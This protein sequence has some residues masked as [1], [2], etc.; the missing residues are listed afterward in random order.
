ML[1][2]IREHQ[3]PAEELPATGRRHSTADSPTQQD[4]L[5]GSIPVDETRLETEARLLRLRLDLVLSNP[6]WKANC[7]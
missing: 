1:E 6:S 7:A 3:G 5:D 4:A 2:L